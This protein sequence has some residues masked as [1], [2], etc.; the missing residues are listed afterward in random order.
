MILIMNSLL[1]TLGFLLLELDQVGQF[2][3]NIFPMVL[4]VALEYAGF[5]G[6]LIDR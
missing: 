1:I 5:V 4:D 3:F 6:S 2:D